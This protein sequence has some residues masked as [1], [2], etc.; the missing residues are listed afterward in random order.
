MKKKTQNNKNHSLHHCEIVCPIFFLP[1]SCSFLRSDSSGLTIIKR[2]NKV[3][4]KT[5][6]LPL[7]GVKKKEKKRMKRK[8]KESERERTR[9]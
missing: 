8:K 3:V 6:A 4:T 1:L 7:K 9:L 2:K 5:N